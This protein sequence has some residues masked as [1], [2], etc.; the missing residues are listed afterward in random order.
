MDEASRR[1]L[2]EAGVELRQ[3]VPKRSGLVGFDFDVL[4]GDGDE[5]G[6]LVVMNGK[7]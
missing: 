5:D 4:E 7:K 6:Q 2:G 1:V 3:F